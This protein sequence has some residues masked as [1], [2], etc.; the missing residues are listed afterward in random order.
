MM[1]F[2]RFRETLGCPRELLAA[3]LG[4]SVKSVERWERGTPPSRLAQRE[5]D[6]FVEELRKD[7]P[8]IEDKHAAL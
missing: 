7:K 2:K 4:V 8:K 1:D 6:R 5:I 3:V